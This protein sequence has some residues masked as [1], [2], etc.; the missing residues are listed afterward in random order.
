MGKRKKAT[1]IFVTTIIFIYG[2]F[3]V[4]ETINLSSKT[5]DEAFEKFINS[6]F[7]TDGA[8]NEIG[9]KAFYRVDNY[10]F[11]PFE[12][13]NN[14]SLVQFEK[15][16]FGWK[17]KYYSHNENGDYSYSSVQSSKNN[18][19]HGVIPKDLVTETKNIKVNGID[20]EII[21]LNDKAGIWIMM[22]DNNED[23]LNNINIDFLNAGGNVV[24]DQL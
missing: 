2:I 15:G 8:Q 16:I 18:L 10:T 24:V 9:D 11:V 14:V 20:A 12:V 4:I 13:G 1:L 21:M 17:R 3:A 19:F 5:V 23:N 7:K 22:N 6:E